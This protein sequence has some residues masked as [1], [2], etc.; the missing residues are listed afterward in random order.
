MAVL[1]DEISTQDGAPIELYRFV[2]TYT[3]YRFTS[4]PKNIVNA[5]GTWTAVPISRNDISEGTQEDEDIALDLEMPASLQIVTDYAIS[6]APPTL[7]LQILRL[8]PND[9]NDTLEIW[10]GPVISWTIAKRIAKCRVPALFAYL[11]NKPLPRIKYQGPC[12]HVLGDRFC[13]VDLSDPLYSLDTTI[14]TIVGSVV[15]IA[16]TTTFS[17]NFCVG[18]QMIASGERRMIVSHS[19]EDFVLATPFS[20]NVVVT[21]A[22][23]IESGCNHAF[24]GD[25]KTKYNNGDNFGGFPLVPPRNPF[26]GRI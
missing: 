11:F 15:T 10:N 14:S 2:G 17:D 19:G 5:E 6:I 8:H 16:D 12:N 9:L 18:G 13:K 25:C 26:G 3:T 4:N 20:P 23:T 1:D 7:N 24:E 21:E 22:V